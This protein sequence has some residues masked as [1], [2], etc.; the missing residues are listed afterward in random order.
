MIQSETARDEV[1]TSNARRVGRSRG[2][3]NLPNGHYW[4][5]FRQLSNLSLGRFTVTRNHQ[6]GL[7]HLEHG[8]SAYKP[9]TLSAIEG[10]VDSWLCIA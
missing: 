3:D 7:L 10:N 5:G 2:L 9:A 1:K 6:D 4:I 8:D